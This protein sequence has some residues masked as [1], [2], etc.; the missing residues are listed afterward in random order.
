MLV[1][2]NSVVLWHL[3]VANEE[4]LDLAVSYHSDY[5]QKKIRKK[6]QYSVQRCTD[7]TFSVPI[8]GLWVYKIIITI[9][10]LIPDWPIVT[11]PD[12]A[13]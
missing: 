12:P 13:V 7:L 1:K 2:R 4:S 6:W 10:Y 3:V 9:K 8:P 11:I 5:N